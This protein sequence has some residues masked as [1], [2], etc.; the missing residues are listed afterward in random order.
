M[1]DDAR[2]GDDS[3][4]RSRQR[5]TDQPATDGQA[6]ATDGEAIDRL[7]L[8]LLGGAPQQVGRFQYHYGNDRW[9]W[10]DAVASMHGYNPGDVEPTTDLV[11]SHNH[12]DDLAQVKALLRQSE[13]PFSSRHRIRT[14]TGETRTVVVVGHAVTDDDGQVVATRGFYI[15]ITDGEYADLQRRLAEELQTI[16]P[17]RSII[18]QAKGMLMALYAVNEDAAF[19]ILRW[20]SQQLNVKLSTVAARLVDELPGLLQMQAGTRA[21]VDHYLMSRKPA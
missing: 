8:A 4:V 11:L 18:E 13:A 21:P 12:P 10:S 20:R 9:T 6:V 19:A 16:L 5:L 17:T 3:N 14:T 1:A 15:D 2:H 7:D